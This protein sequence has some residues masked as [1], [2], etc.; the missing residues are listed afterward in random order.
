MSTHDR[1]GTFH[2]FRTAALALSVI[3]LAACGSITGIKDVPEYLD[4]DFEHVGPRE[5]ITNI[6][7]AR[8]KLGMSPLQVKNRLGAPMLSAKDQDDRWDYVLKKGQ[9]AAEE[10]VPYAVY[11]KDQKVVRLAPLTPPPTPLADQATPASVA[12]TAIV[13]APSVAAPEAVAGEEVMAPEPSLAVGAD[14][15]DAAAIN[16]LLN[17]WAA[18]WAAK[19]VEAYLGFYASTFE[20]GKKSRESWEKQRRARLSQPATIAVNLSDVQIDLQSEA[21]ATVKFKQD[22]SSNRYKDSG[23]KIL[24]LS[25]AGGTWKI[26]SE[27][28]QK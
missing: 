23:M 9:G 20:H 4:S 1:T 12:D 7:L 14:V 3:V 11:F 10:F 26:Q 2:F 13:D 28:F 5:F 17:A 6:D 27:E 22:Y 18:A 24:T 25:K 21:L 15:G 8:I 19:D 16:D